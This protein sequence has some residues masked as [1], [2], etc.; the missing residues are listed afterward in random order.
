MPLLQLEVLD[1]EGPTRWR[2][3]LSEARGRYLADHEVRLDSS[4]SE[5]EAFCDLEKY[6]RWHSSIERRL[7]QESELLERIGGWIGEQVLGPV[8]TAILAHRPAVVR[9][10]LPIEAKALAYRPL[11][12]G[13]V[14]GL[15][16]AVQGASLIIEKAEAQDGTVKPVGRR[17]RMLALFSLPTD[18]NALN[19]RRERYALSRQVHRIARRN[20]T[21]I[22]LRVLQ[23][24]VTRQRLQD[25]IEE[26]EGWDIL[27][28][29]GH[30]LPAGLL[31]ELPNGRRDLI[32]GEDLVGILDPV[33]EQLKLVT[34]SS[35]YSAALTVN[36]TLQSLGLGVSARKSSG[37]IGASEQVDDRPLT[38][39]ADV[40]VERLGCAVLAMRFPVGDDFAIDLGAELYEALLSKQQS[41]PRAL[42]LALPKAL[43]P[44]PTPGTPALSVATPA[45]F[46]SSAAT[47]TLKAP[48]GMPSGF[49][50]MNLRMAHFPSEPERFVGRI[51]AMVRAAEALAPES[52]WTGVL[53]HGM[54]G[55]G[56]SA[57]ALELAY[58][59][60]Q[61]FETLV[62]H[63]A[64]DEGQDVANAITNLALDL[65]TQ[66]PGLRLVH[67]VESLRELESFL[68]Q[69]TEYLERTNIL[70][71]LDNLEALLTESGQ[72][73]DDRWAMML[74]ALIN[75]RGLSRVVLTSRRR[76]AVLDARIRVETIHALAL[77]EA[78]LLARELP[79]LG[80]L[81]DAGEGQEPSA[82]RQLL[83]RTL[84]VVQGHPKLIE[85]ADSQAKD[86]TILQAR[87]DEADQAWVAGGTQISAFFEEGHSAA[88]DNDFLRVLDGWARGAASALPE[89]AA[90]LFGVIS[91]IEEKD[92]VEPVLQATWPVIWSQLEIS[93]E[94]PDPEFAITA[95]EEN[96]L[97]VRESLGPQ[98][99]VHYQVHP[100][101]SAVGREVGGQN[102]QT[103]VDSTLALY[104]L[105]GLQEGFIREADKRGGSLLIEA[106]RRSIPYLLRQGQHEMANNAVKAILY[107]DSSP[108]ALESL[109]PLVR[110][111][112]QEGAGSETG[113][114]HY[115]LLAKSLRH[116]GAEDSEA[117]L[118]EMV[119]L[120]AANGELG[121]ASITAHELMLLLRESGRLEEA[122]NVAE[123]MKRYTIDGGYGPWTQL[124]DEAACLAIVEMQGQ[125]AE[126]RDGMKRLWERMA[127]LPEDDPRSES[128]PS[129]VRE[130]VASWAVREDVLHVWGTAATSLDEH[131][132][133]LWCF[134]QLDD[135]KK[136]RGASRLERAHDR[137]NSYKSL[138]HLNRLDEAR[139]LLSECRATFEEER[140]IQY[141]ALVFV[142]LAELEDRLGHTRAAV[143]FE[144]NALRL[145]Y[146]RMESAVREIA[147]MHFNLASCLAKPDGDIV[148]AAANRLAATIILYQ[149]GTGIDDV[150]NTL[151]KDVTIASVVADPASIP[152]SFEDL[153]SV[154]EQTEGV[155]FR[156]LVERLAT[157]GPNGDEAMEEVL[158][159]VEAVATED[160]LPTLSII[161]MVLAAA[162]G[163]AEAA[164]SLEHFL[165]GRT[166]TP[167]D[168]AFGASLRRVIAGERG[169]QL[170][171]GLT[172]DHQRLVEQILGILEEIGQDGVVKGGGSRKRKQRR[173]ER[174]WK[175]R[176]R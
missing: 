72:W 122:L 125:Y 3:R 13:H 156:S 12:L 53:F 19:L 73:R 98:Q 43:A 2:W 61:L 166:G 88:T 160:F 134:K 26:A 106:A 48:R 115:E 129:H 167:E 90:I 38:A 7:E 151:A 76:P 99:L 141:L 105:E 112:T 91:S 44:A 158:A 95:L 130:L 37:P 137:F 155:E 168:E 110:R 59:H 172:P 157:R 21:A 154:V 150:V 74:N 97:L 10:R 159:R 40:F 153:C 142:A 83:A 113:T 169:Q 114:E 123:E 29:S 69:L 28:I 149:L 87:L 174:R 45:L 171:S 27:H 60:E 78:V 4:T 51:G 176:R 41:L 70:L 170:L 127:S 15:P 65:E 1:Y 104:W 84:G 17:L 133:A 119:R 54:A 85:L 18:T 64:P 101:V 24:G 75:H 31:L 5:F 96:G 140:D 131:D 33:A 34:L 25:A 148:T 46:G 135:I 128:A 107:R 67:L 66:I 164:S 20:Q 117:R 152:T 118:R 162:S 23:Y 50:P 77:D 71:V 139:L 11:E 56:K 57:C 126:A 68:P 89:H 47:L 175:K 138:F 116:S 6:L 49:D 16:L 62:F 35:C 81:L 58:G 103:A 124:F 92:R 22:D 94:A 109:L 63:R 8:G 111:I 145:A 14:N 55:A 80:K 147:G 9:L 173:R 144:H 42:Q 32:A 136:Q 93:D 100:G 36:Q 132:E 143:E 39:V 82:R 79:N 146:T 30:G 102:T 161:P 121:R 163:N 120:A 52:N 86:P 108:Q 165:S